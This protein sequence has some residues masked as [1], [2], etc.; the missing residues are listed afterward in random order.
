MDKYLKRATVSF[1]TDSVVIRQTRFRINN[2]KPW[3]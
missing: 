2:V 1:L 3:N